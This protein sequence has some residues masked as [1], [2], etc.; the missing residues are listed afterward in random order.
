MPED[1]DPVHINGRQ[2]RNDIFDVLE[3]SGIPL[4]NCLG[5]EHIAG[6]IGAPLLLGKKFVPTSQLFPVV[7][8]S[9]AAAMQ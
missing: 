2:C 1:I 6:V 9:A 3:V 8:P 7:R 5:G 4:T